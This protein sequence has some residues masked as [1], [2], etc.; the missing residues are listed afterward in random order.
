MVSKIL[1]TIIVASIGFA[2]LSAPVNA[3]P[4]TLTFDTPQ[5]ESPTYMEAGMTITQGV[6]GTS[7][8][9]VNGGW[10]NT[11]CCP[12]PNTDIYEL[13]A[14]SGIFDLLSI[15]IIHSDY[16]DPIQ[17]DG[18]FNNALVSM[19]TI[20]A[21]DF[22]ALSFTGFT[23]LDLVVITT[24]GTYSD[25]KF[26]NLT[27]EAWSQPEPEPEPVPEPGT[28]ALFGLGL[29]ALGFARRRKTA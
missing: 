5:A 24:I 21:F 8:V 29:A 26:D 7:G 17:F 22:G 18:Y 9:V 4:I 16:G 23:G 19:I 25:S 1:G 20:N 28:L 12:T 10:W 3:A 15:D 2:G 13:T 6:G 14:S 11:P 27:Y